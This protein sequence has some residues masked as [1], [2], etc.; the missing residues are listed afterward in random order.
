VTAATA[1]TTVDLVAEPT[2]CT[3]CGKLRS[4]VGHLIRA[5]VTDVTICDECVA[6]CLDI[7]DEA[8]P[9]GWGGVHGPRTGSGRI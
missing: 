3:F 6:L 8:I 7:L 4:Q 5:G 2:T 1:T 9:G